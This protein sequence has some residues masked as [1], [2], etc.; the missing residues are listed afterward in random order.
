MGEVRDKGMR[1]G[2]YDIGLEAPNQG[3]S[4]CSPTPPTLPLASPQP[5]PT[6]RRQE[7]SSCS[8]PLPPLLQSGGMRG[9]ERTGSGTE[10]YRSKAGDICMPPN[11][12]E[13]P[14]SIGGPAAG[15]KT[16]PRYGQWWHSWA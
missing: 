14:I 2:V 5:V 3:N 12:S 1:D 11:A 13:P 10:G 4:S 15:C 7:T 16:K 8:P 9:L 6:G